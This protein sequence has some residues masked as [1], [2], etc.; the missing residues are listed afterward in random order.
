MFEDDDVA[1]RSHYPS[2]FPLSMSTRFPQPVSPLSRRRRKIAR[3]GRT[4]KSPFRSKKLTGDR[5][6]QPPSRTVGQPWFTKNLA[7]IPQIT[8]KPHQRP[9]PRAKS[10]Q[11]KQ[12]SNRSKDQKENTLRAVQ[13]WKT[14]KMQRHN[15]DNQSDTDSSV[16]KNCR[17]STTTLSNELALFLCDVSGHMIKEFRKFDEDFSGEL[18]KEEF[19]ALM[20]DLRKHENFPLSRQ[21]A[22]L[23]YLAFDDDQS[24]SVS[25]REVVEGLFKCHH[26][27]PTNILGQRLLPKKIREHHNEKHGLKPPSPRKKSVYTPLM[28]GYGSGMPIEY[29]RQQPALPTLPKYQMSAFERRQNFLWSQPENMYLNMS[30]LDNSGVTQ[31]NG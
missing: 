15:K 23:L 11:S 31:F 14:R 27:C 24:G 19:E 21:D 13:R 7:R 4:S 17:T 30:S 26:R 8:L 5:T 28:L 25:T 1:I 6:P 18:S 2:S 10:I 3:L 29:K 9:A 16:G 20:D 22:D 12:I